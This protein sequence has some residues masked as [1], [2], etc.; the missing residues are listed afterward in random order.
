MTTEELN[1]WEKCPLFSWRKIVL[2][3]WLTEISESKKEVRGAE[4][5][6][7]VKPEDVRS[8]K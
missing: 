3:G 2:R 7:T 6:S 4:Q 5:S 1:C 8:K